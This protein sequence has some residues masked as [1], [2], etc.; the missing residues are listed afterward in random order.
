[1]GVKSA[2]GDLTLSASY[3]DVPGTTLEITPNV[4]SILKVTAVFHFSTISPGG[5]HGTVRLNAE[6]QAEVASLNTTV[7][8]AGTVG[9]VYL[10]QLPA[11]KN[12]IK[13][14]AKRNGAA[15]KTLAV[16]TRYLYELTA[17]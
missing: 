4:A 15:G 14:R 10:L 12:T 3:E 13:L 2:S 17:A 7:E 11:A 1:M 5:A 8:S 9:Q 6:D 16:S